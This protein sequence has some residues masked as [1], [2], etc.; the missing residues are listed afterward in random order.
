MTEESNIKRVYAFQ[1]RDISDCRIAGHHWG[2]GAR[3]ILWN[4][5][6][7]M[8]DMLVQSE[9]G[10]PWCHALGVVSYHGARC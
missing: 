6:S 1:M 10:S 8:H 9:C 7:I 4:T 5:L 2:V 3:T